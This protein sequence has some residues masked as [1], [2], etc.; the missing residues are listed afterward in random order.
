MNC[1]E[2]LYSDSIGI[3][4]DLLSLL[5]PFAGTYQNF[6]FLTVGG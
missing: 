6:L 1:K 5:K 2:M 4:R 3:A